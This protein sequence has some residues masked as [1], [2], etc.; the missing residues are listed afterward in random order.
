MLALRTRGDYTHV[1]QVFCSIIVTAALTLTANTQQL[2]CLK[3]EIKLRT[4]SLKPALLPQRC[5]QITN[6][7]EVDGAAMA[8]TL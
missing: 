6:V 2:P 1:A 3:T 4:G 7:Y 5:R 8:L